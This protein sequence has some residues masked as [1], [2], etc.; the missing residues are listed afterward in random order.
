MEG[1]FGLVVCV[2]GGRGGM[3]KVVNMWFSGGNCV[4]VWIGLTCVSGGVGLKL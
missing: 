4:H 2:K 1:N 3:G